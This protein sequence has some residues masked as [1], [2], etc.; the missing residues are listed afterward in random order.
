M[1]PDDQVIAIVD[2]LMDALGDAERV[3]GPLTPDV[4]REALL[5]FVA[6]QVRA[7]G[8][9]TVAD[10]QLWGQ[11]AGERI[12]EQMLALLAIGTSEGRA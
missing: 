9:T 8:L 4:A 7:F 5:L 1:N 3:A 2:V 11:Q 10:I 12:A 6:T